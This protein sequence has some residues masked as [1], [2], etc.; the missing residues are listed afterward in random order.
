M[1]AIFTNTAAAMLMLAGPAVALQAQPEQPV[2]STIEDIPD[3][4]RVSVLDYGEG[5]KRALRFE[6]AEGAEEAFSMTMSMSM[7]NQIGEFSMPIELPLM[8]MSG[9]TRIESIEGDLITSSGTFGKLELDGNPMIIGLM[10]QALDAFDRVTLSTVTRTDGS[11]VSAEINMPQDASPELASQVETMRQSAESNA[12]RL[13]AEPI[14]LGAVWYADV[15]TENA[16]IRSVLRTTYTLREVEGTVITLDLETTQ[17]TPGQTFESPEA[18]GVLVTVESASTT[19]KGFVE[20]DLTKL[21]PIYGRSKST[22]ET[23]LTMKLGEEV[24][25][26]TTTVTTEMTYDAE[27]ADSAEGK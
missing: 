9:T 19:G 1:K 17:F 27:E 21:N 5:E 16:G 10:E 12:V 24:Q 22:S 20:C 14:G 25:A 26:M 15:P 2:Y 3:E 4:T 7:T 11:Y 6:L 23:E 18:P 13:P 8:T